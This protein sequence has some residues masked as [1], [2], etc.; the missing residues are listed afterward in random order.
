MM[1]IFSDVKMTNYVEGAIRKSP[2]VVSRRLAQSGPN[3]TV[4][5]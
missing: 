4:V 3:P 5:L 1:Y 2:D